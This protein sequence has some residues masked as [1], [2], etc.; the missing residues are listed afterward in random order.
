MK[1]ILTILASISLVSTPALSTVSCFEIGDNA[2]LYLSSKITGD[3]EYSNKKAIIHFNNENDERAYDYSPLITDF[4]KLMGS[5]KFD[6]NKYRAL[7]MQFLSEIEFFDYLVNESNQ[8]PTWD[9]QVLDVNPQP[10]YKAS[11]IDKND[12]EEEFVLS[13]IIRVDNYN[14]TPTQ[15]NKDIYFKDVIVREWIFS[16]VNDGVGLYSSTKN[17]KKVDI[18]VRNQNLT[19]IQKNAILIEN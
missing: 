11:H 4:L 9:Y 10:A 17:T 15:S 1:R 14:Q 13:K 7:Q 5:D 12:L 8:T 6:T 18:Y 16:E 2:L 19:D 3:Y